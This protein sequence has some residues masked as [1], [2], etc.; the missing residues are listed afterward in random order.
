MRFYG[1]LVQWPE[2]PPIMFFLPKIIVLISSIGYHAIIFVPSI[3]S[4]VVPYHL[5][6]SK[7]VSC[8]PIF[9]FISVCDFGV[10]IRGV[11]SVL[12]DYGIVLISMPLDYDITT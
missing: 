3:S 12:P 1:F 11:W 7:S 4:H 6:C 10:W 2:D 9:S 5:N 8:L